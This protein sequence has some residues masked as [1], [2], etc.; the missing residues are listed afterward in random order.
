MYLTQ[1]LFNP[2]GCII[3]AFRAQFYDMLG[4][5]TFVP[6]VLASTAR[7]LTQSSRKLCP[8]TYRGALYVNQAHSRLLHLD[9]VQLGLIDVKV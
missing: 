9:V 2:Q 7:K 1:I 6:Y 4:L 8:A 3:S 5:L